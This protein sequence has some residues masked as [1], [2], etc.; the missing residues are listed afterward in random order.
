[1]ALVTED[2]TGRA[3]A[4]SYITLAAASTY[5]TNRGNAAWAALAS[6]A[7]REQAL[8]KATDYMVQVYRLRWA[9]RR[10]N[11]TQALDWPRYDVPIRDTGGWLEYY[12]NDAV[13]TAVA[14][15]CAELA[16][17]AS[18]ADLTPDL[19]QA[20]KRKKVGP[21]EVEYQDYSTATK[22]YGAIDGLLAPMLAA[23]GSVRVL[24][25]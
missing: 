9:G 11:A 20:V 24:R 13:P 23:G 3:D 21:V 6:D 25:G 22:T 7:V 14:N 15:A 4:E 2:G 5:H 8:R 12:A 19:G 16:L 10:R 18:A 1:M 17:K